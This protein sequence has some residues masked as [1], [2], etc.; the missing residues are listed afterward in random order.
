MDYLFLAIATITNTTNS[1][2]WK[3]VSTETRSNS[4]LHAKSAF[5]FVISS[6]IVLLWAA[7]QKTLL[8]PSLTTVII[9]LAFAASRTI[10]Q[11]SLLLAMRIGAASITQLIFSLGI[12]FP[13]VYGAIA[14][15]EEISLLQYVGIAFFFLSLTLINNP[16][17]D[18]SFRL[19]WLSLSLL[20]ATC[21]G[22][23]AILQKL[24]QATEVS[25]ERESL[26][27]LALGFSALF[28]LVLSLF[29]RHKEGRLAASDTQA[30]ASTPT[31][32]AD[33]SA[34]ATRWRDKVR[35]VLFLLLC[36][37]CIGVVSALNFMLAGRLPAVIQFP[38]YNIGSIVLVGL[39][40][41]IFYK[42]KL[43]LMQLLGFGIGCIA[44]LFIGLF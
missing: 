3:R 4:L 12:L 32:S 9:A 19:L 39:G 38:I 30:E 16:K 36:G 25:A 14:L 20:A 23:N 7:V 27:I 26:I 24:H 44:I 2:F 42:E 28:S 17:A 11:A 21:S 5:I 34:T 22:I 41:R 33:T 15:N 8:V 37:L 6:L 43:T 18:K 31:E 1:L 35:T 10:L 13:I 40:G 29:A